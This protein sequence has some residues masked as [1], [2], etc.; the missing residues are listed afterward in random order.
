[1][2]SQLLERADKPIPKSPTH[3]L[4]VDILNTDMSFKR[5]S[6]YF[7]PTDNWKVVNGFEGAKAVANHIEDHL[8]FIGEDLSSLAYKAW[9]IDIDTQKVCHQFSIK[10]YET[11]Y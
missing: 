8:K 11:V 10:S 9:L 1:M 3:A 4:I 2:I 5:V 7:N 6:I